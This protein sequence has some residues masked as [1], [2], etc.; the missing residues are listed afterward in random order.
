[1]T[2][3]ADSRVAGIVPIMIDVLNMQRTVEHTYRTYGRW[4]QAWQPYEKL[5]IFEWLGTPQMDVLLK[6]EDPFTY[7]DRLTMPK[8]I[9]RIRLREIFAFKRSARHSGVRTSM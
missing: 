8:L 4:P 7:R 9:G 2:A 1:M 6:I 3:A 5:G